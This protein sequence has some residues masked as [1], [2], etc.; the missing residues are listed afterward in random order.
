[1]ANPDSDA[2]SAVMDSLRKAAA[3]FPGI[4]ES[5]FFDTPVL[6]VRGKYIAGPARVGGT[7]CFKIHS[8]ERRMLMESEP[9]KYL[10]TDHYRAVL[11]D[12]STY[13]LARI[14]QMTERDLY[15]RLEQAYLLHASKKQ[16]EAYRKSIG[17]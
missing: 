16:V 10:L 12:G 9:D 13:V 11:K 4:E 1:M 17:R 8:E 14:D 3:S 7:L 5:S 2:R 6:K 15:E